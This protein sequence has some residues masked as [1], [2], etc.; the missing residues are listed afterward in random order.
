M[1]RRPAL[2]AV[3]RVGRLG[4]GGSLLTAI[5]ANLVGNVSLAEMLTGAILDSAY[6]G[7]V[8]YAG[9]NVVLLD[10][11]AAAG[12]ARDD[13]LPRR[14]RSTSDRCWQASTSL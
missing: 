9:A 10:P 11:P 6:V 5:V 4:R 2:T 8:L 12:A 1:P 14:S 3:V 13:A 7:L